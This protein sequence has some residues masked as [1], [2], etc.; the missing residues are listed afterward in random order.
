M[1]DDESASEVIGRVM[2]DISLDEADT[3]QPPH[4]EACGQRVELA[5]FA[6]K[7]M[8]GG[9]ETL[10]YCE[11]C[12]R[13]ATIMGTTVSV[14]RKEM[15]RILA[16]VL[17]KREEAS[18]LRDEVMALRAGFQQVH[19]VL[20]AEGASQHPSAATLGR[21]ARYRRR[22]ERVGVHQI[23]NRTRAPRRIARRHVSACIT[24]T[25]SM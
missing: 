25:S 22:D 2:R 12:R 1:S 5:P 17:L 24:I 11:D 3:D 21:R 14:S 15:L 23:Q 19:Y 13:T 8:K 9:S 16:R 20:T 6:V 7:R 18:T 10:M 4:C